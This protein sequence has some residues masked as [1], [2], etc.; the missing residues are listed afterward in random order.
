MR[1]DS[2]PLE[3]ANED[4][5]AT[6]SNYQ[7][8][9]DEVS[10]DSSEQEMSSSESSKKSI[11]PKPP[12]PKAQQ[13]NK[14]V[15]ND[16]STTR[17][18]VL[19]QEE[20]EDSIIHSHDQRA[21]T[22]R[23]SHSNYGV[24]GEEPFEESSF[25]SYFERKSS[26]DKFCNSSYYDCGD[27]SENESA[28]SPPV[29]NHRGS[30]K[31]SMRKYSKQT[32]TTVQRFWNSDHVFLYMALFICVLF[33]LVYFVFTWMKYGLQENNGATFN[34]DGTIKMSI[35]PSTVPILTPDDVLS[36]AITKG[37][38]LSPTGEVS[39]VP[40]VMPTMLLT[41]NLS[42]EPSI[43][44]TAIKSEGPTSV[45]SI[46]PSF[47]PSQTASFEPTSFPSTSIRP[48][49][50]PSI[51]PTSTPTSTPSISALPSLSSLP[52]SAPSMKVCTCTPLHYNFKLDLDARCPL[53]ISKNAGIESNAYCEYQTQR[54]HTNFNAIIVRELSIIEYDTN[55]SAIRALRKKSI[56]L[57]GES[58]IYESA[59]SI[60][61]TIGGLSGI[62][63]ALNEEGEFIMKFEVNF[64]NICEVLPFSVG[65]H[66]GFLH[67][68]SITIASFLFLC[69]FVITNN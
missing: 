43:S 7:Y 66:L 1:N 21:K 29:T 25:D 9:N 45:P 49:S 53:K 62:M 11:L 12:P 40:S 41:K 20:K 32:T 67:L 6:F 44:P 34:D 63:K 4:S 50:F 47:F 57:D 39:L 60:G 15:Y 8:S 17:Y 22:D 31:D 33:G 23:C 56:M 38:S 46:Q 3:S 42:Y 68:V 26:D 19:H 37:P 69:I 10:I 48:S 64:T 55:G 52:S 59:G 36:S 65:N 16:S 58:F 18:G 27:S 35:A 5:E 54:N 13:R 61:E 30:W 24:L 51:H 28:N 2:S 14:L